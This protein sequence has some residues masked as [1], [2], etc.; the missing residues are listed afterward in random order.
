M[1]RESVDRETVLARMK[2]QIDE[3]IKRRLCDQVVINDEQQPLLQQVL[4]LHQELLDLS[5]SA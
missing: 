2:R 5:K 3:E 4:D 1:Q